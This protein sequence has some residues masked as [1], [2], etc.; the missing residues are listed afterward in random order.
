MMSRGLPPLPPM[1]TILPGYIKS[2]NPE[3]GYGFLRSDEIP[4][5]DIHFSRSLLPP[6]VQDMPWSSLNNVPVEFEL[7]VNHRDGKLRTERLWVVD[8]SLDRSRG[9]SH[10][11]RLG[12]GRIPAARAGPGMGGGMRGADDGVPPPDLDEATVNSM[13]QFLE[14]RGGVM[15]H[16]KFANAFPG[17]KKSQLEPHFRLVPEGPNSGGRWQVMLPDQEPLA[18]EELRAREAEQAEVQQPLMVTGEI[19]PPPLSLEPSSTLR[20]IGCVK[21]WDARKGYGFVVADGADDVFL[22]RNDLPPEV[23][24]WRGD[25]EGVELTFM[26]DAGSERRLKAVNVHMLLVPDEEGKWQ[27]RRIPKEDRPSAEDCEVEGEE[28]GALMAD[29]WKEAG[30]EEGVKP[31]EEKSD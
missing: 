29:L 3:H 18:P 13:T 19:T 1:G 7:S 10:A 9:M 21:K 20:L 4:R 5:N 23:R 31:G 14:E 28:E 6:D 26:L 16:G 30:V 24:N 17:V 8:P 11:N 25:L 15:D 22:H 12:S 27:L 2:Y